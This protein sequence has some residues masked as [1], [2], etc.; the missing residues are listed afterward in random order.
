MDKMWLQYPELRIE[1]EAVQ[2]IMKKNIRCRDKR[3]ESSLMELIN[4]GGKMLR[5][6]SISWEATLSILS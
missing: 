2:N 5:P 4:S 1:I 6:A 3:I